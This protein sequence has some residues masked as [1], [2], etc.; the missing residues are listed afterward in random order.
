MSTSETMTA[1]TPTAWWLAA[2]VGLVLWLTTAHLGGRTEPWD[3]GL[4]WAGSYPLAIL[5][6]GLFGW[7]FPERPWRWA[8]ILIFSQVPVMFVRGADLGLLPLGLI[9]LGVLSLPA[10]GLSALG[11]GLSRRATGV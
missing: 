7:I 5:L 9:L 8:A 2:I 3:S 11:A 1:R 10:I 4:F 6:A